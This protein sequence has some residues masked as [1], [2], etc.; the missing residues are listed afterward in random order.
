MPT[1][2]SVGDI[3][4]VK[5]VGVLY[6]QTIIYDFA[7][8]IKTIGSGTAD[9]LVTLAAFNAAWQ[10][11]PLSPWAVILSK[12]SPEYSAQYSQMQWIHPTRSPYD[13][14]TNV[15]AA[16]GPGSASSPSASAVLTK[17]INPPHQGGAGHLCLAGLDYAS[18][19]DGRWTG[20]NITAM[21]A[22]GV[23]LL[24]TFTVT[25][26]SGPSI[27]LEPVV[28]RRTDPTNSPV[29]FNFALA[30]VVRTQKR[31]VVGRGI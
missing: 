22:I 4:S 27:F 5:M 31:R 12:L 21:T 9:W 25:P 7:Y 29:I 28:Y 6:G 17:R 23:T 8:R 13:R 18:V 15:V 11:D 30:D 24:Q 2:V 10:S 1:Y 14:L 20:A 16:T 19:A 26:S 3:C